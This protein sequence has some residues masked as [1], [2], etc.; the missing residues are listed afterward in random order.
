MTDKE[1]ATRTGVERGPGMG[2]DCDNVQGN[3]FVP[4]SERDAMDRPNKAA[5][6]FAVK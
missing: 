6:I 4:V 1:H 3:G 5:I 2:F